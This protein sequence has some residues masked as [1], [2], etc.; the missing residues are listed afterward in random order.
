VRSHEAG[1]EQALDPAD[2]GGVLGGDGARRPGGPAKRLEFHPIAGGEGGEGGVIL[3]ARFKGF[4]Q[5]E[6]KS[7]AGFAVDVWIGGRALQLRELGVIDRFGPQDGHARQGSWAAGRVV[8]QGAVTFDRLVDPP[9]DGQAACQVEARLGRAR[10]DVDCPAVG[11]GGLAPQF[12]RLADGAKIVLSVEMAWVEADDGAQ[13]L[14]RALQRPGPDVDDGQGIGRADVRRGASFEASIDVRRIAQPAGGKVAAGLIQKG[15]D[16]ARFQA[17]A[18]AALS[19]FGSPT[20]RRDHR[21]LSWISI[22]KV[23]GA[24][25]LM[26][27][28]TSVG[29]TPGGLTMKPLVPSVPMVLKTLSTKAITVKRFLASVQVARRFTWE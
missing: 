19:R 4:A 17:P 25:R 21:N 12:K 29:F 1:A 15:I 20:S 18:P 28:S 7:D 3:A 24:V 5:G 13:A 6:V 26:N 22:P 16:Q 27:L 8:G 2:G 14:S 10:V 11:P 9:Q 23:R